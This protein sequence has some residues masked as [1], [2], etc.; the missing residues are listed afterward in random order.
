V[1]AREILH[2]SNP[3]N[4]DHFARTSPPHPPLQLP[5]LRH[6]AATA[7]SEP[8]VARTRALQ[9]PN[10]DSHLHF[11][12]P[13]AFLQPT[14]LLQSKDISYS[15]QHT[16]ATQTEDNKARRAPDVN[17]TISV[18]MSLIALRRT[19]SVRRRPS[20]TFIEAI[21]LRWGREPSPASLWRCQSEEMV[22]GSG[23][24]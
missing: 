14:P 5:N 3:Q 15:C 2:P 11:T 20:A 18:H 17:T 7:E 1:T 21:F 16:E 6:R 8:S 9:L 12:Y 24:S 10:V 19:C 4:N 13:G 23:D 22:T